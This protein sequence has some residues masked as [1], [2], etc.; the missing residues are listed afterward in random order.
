[1]WVLQAIE[2]VYRSALGWAVRHKLVVAGLA[3]ASFVGMGQIMG[4]MG[5]EF[6]NGN[7]TPFWNITW[8]W[9]SSS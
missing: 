2:D 4:L 1:M 8:T 5:N 3:I 6:V 7:E 9:D